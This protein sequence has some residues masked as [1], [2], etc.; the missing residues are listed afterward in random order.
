MEGVAGDIKSLQSCC[1]VEMSPSDSS[2]RDRALQAQWELTK[3]KRLCW[4]VELVKWVFGYPPTLITSLW[5]LSDVA[6]P[7]GTGK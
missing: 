6:P 7:S 1:K 3:S 4:L 2:I 5:L